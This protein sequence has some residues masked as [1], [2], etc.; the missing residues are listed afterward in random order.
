MCIKSI[1]CTCLVNNRMASECCRTLTSFVA[2]SQQGSVIHNGCMFMNNTRE[3]VPKRPPYKRLKAV[4]GLC[5][6][7]KLTQLFGIDHLSV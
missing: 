3:G 6:K 5:Y 1:P 7:K 4:Q 2:G